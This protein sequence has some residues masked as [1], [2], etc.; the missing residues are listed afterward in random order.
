MRQVLHTGCLDPHLLLWWAAPYMLQ[1]SPKGKNGDCIDLNHPCFQVSACPEC[2]QEYPEKPRRHRYAEKSAGKLSGLQQ[3]RAKILESSWR[4]GQ[5]FHSRIKVI[6]E[7]DWRCNFARIQHS[8]C[9]NCI[10]TCS[11]SSVADQLLQTSDF[12]PPGS[13]PTFCK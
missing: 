9:S 11:K 5:Y 7:D 8:T 6:Q 13:Q 12:P 10:H 3:E 2:R 1:V 4:A